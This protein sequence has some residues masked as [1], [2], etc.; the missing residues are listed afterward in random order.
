MTHHNLLCNRT[1]NISSISDPLA[2]DSMLWPPVNDRVADTDQHHCRLDV[3]SWGTAPGRVDDVSSPGASPH[4]GKKKISQSSVTVSQ[5]TQSR[6]P[7][8]RQSDPELRLR[9]REAA[10]LWM[11]GRTDGR[12]DGGMDLPTVCQHVNTSASRLQHTP[13]QKRA[14]MWRTSSKHLY[15]LRIT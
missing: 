4:D 13:A 3:S 12:E 9:H 14:Q 5:Q 7:T 8:Q 6:H 15:Q 10:L 1:P 2:C 11:E